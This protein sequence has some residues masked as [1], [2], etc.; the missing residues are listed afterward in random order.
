MTSR[1]LSSNFAG[2][3]WDTVRRNIWALALSL[4]SFLLTMPLPMAMIIQNRQQQIR[5]L[6]KIGQDIGNLRKDM[7]QQVGFL[8]GMNNV[9]VKLAVIGLAVVC[10]VALFRYL[11]SRQQTDFY[12]AL[13]VSRGKLFAVNFTAG[14]VSVLA[15]YLVSLLL[16]GAIASMGGCGEAFW[17]LGLI[18]G[19]ALNIT[20][21]LVIYA[22]SILCTVLCGNTIVS[23][24]LLTWTM[25][26]LP[27]ISAIVT[28]LQSHFY[29]T[30]AGN[31]DLWTILLGRGSPII[32]Y[33]AVSTSLQ[34]SGY[35]LSQTWLVMEQPLRLGS[36]LG[37]FF[38][39]AV[40]AL[41]LSYVMFCRR[42]SECAGSAL[43]FSG[44]RLPLKIW[45][46]LVMT[47]V[48]AMVFANLASDFWMPF[49]MVL[50]GILTHCLMEMIYAFDFRA[51]LRHW[52][53]GL[54]ILVVVCASVGAIKLDLFGYDKALPQEGNIKAVSVEAWGGIR[55]EYGREKNTG[56]QYFAD[57]TTP[58]TIA[59]A[60]RIAELGVQSLEHIEAESPAMLKS[61][62]ISLH[63]EMKNGSQMARQYTIYAFSEQEVAEIEALLAQIRCSEEYIVRRD[64]AYMYRRAD[65]LQDEEARKYVQDGIE[66]YTM[67]SQGVAA[68]IREP[69][70]VDAIYAALQRDALRLTPESLMQSVPRMYLKLVSYSGDGGGYYSKYNGGPYYSSGYDS[71]DQIILYDNYTETLRL[72]EQYT[73][74]KPEVLPASAV[75]AIEV[76]CVPVQGS[77]ELVE[78]DEIAVKLAAGQAVVKAVT[79]PAEI[80]QLLQNATDE[81]FDADSSDQR[82]N[83][84]GLE[85]YFFLVTYLNQNDGGLYLRYPGTNAP[86]ELLK[87]YFDL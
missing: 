11:H 32:Q 79:D 7:L 9:F 75:R 36:L 14:F 76:E 23:L 77:G 51:A 27:L 20:F 24:L 85:D 33:L 21:F 86:Y 59:A 1:S 80:E 39:I 83:I 15:A 49:G 35:L 74:Q 67:Q 25:F 43:A 84:P 70:Q 34:P 45:C 71:E 37:I 5:E 73:G 63:F 26:S 87:S 69:Q 6:T 82:I 57:L 61:Y 60:A 50:A 46:V 68:T 58:E 28:W 38:A 64:A 16:T 30:F 81:R 52:K 10:G 56:R 31:T 40:V 62:N 41:V 2:M 44:L 18:K 8:A 12:H 55:L 13:P 53:S 42:K 29:S 17:S 78:S 48:G 47:Y 4:L 65:S 66:V 54:L 19:I 22:I 72:I 3:V